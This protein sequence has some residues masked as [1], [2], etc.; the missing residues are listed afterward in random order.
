[1]L[2]L[3]YSSLVLQKLKKPVP[4]GTI[5]LEMKVFPSLHKS[6]QSIVNSCVKGA[7]PFWQKHQTAGKP[8]QG[9]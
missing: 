7:T 9:D 4:Y 8:R 1:M 5:T 6:A 2:F 3:C